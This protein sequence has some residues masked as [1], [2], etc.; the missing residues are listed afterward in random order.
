[1]T[2]LD[3]LLIKIAVAK[4]AARGNH[5]SKLMAENLVAAFREISAASADTSSSVD[6]E[7][8]K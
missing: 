7:A 2:W 3:K 4:A 8:R 6:L 5:Q 1:M